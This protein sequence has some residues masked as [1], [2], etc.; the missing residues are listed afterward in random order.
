[1]FPITNYDPPRYTIKGQERNLVGQSVNMLVL[2]KYI[3]H[4][5]ELPTTVLITGETGTGK[6]L[7]AQ[8]IHYNKPNHADNNYPFVAVACSGIPQ[9]L[10]ESLLFGHVR[11]S[12][13]G[14][15]KDQK[16]KFEYAEGGT[17]FLDEIGDMSPYLQA[18]ILRVLQEKEITPVGSNKSKKV[19]AR[20]VSATNT[21]LETKIKNGEFRA[22]L[23]HRIN[24][25]PVHIP[26]LRDRTEDIEPLCYYFIE[27]FN[28]GYNRQIEGIT[29]NAVKKLKGY[30]WP[31]N[32]RE[33]E[34][35]IERVFV[36]KKS[37]K[38]HFSDIFFEGNLEIPTRIFGRELVADYIKSRLQALGKNQSWLAQE[39][40]ISR[41]AV[42][43]YVSAEYFPEG[44]LRKKLIEVLELDSNL[45]NMLLK[46]NEQNNQN[47]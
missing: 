7:V 31:G 18:K 1:M 43:G 12:F 42:S 35:V 45:I 15:Y 4:L 32:V 36:H 34:N 33:L 9:E 37:G 17:I 25:F 40:R 16:G 10:L 8:A 47:L 46:N 13:T 28:K 19:N 11:G 3:N 39:L 24:V 23:F 21:D 6:E 38:I 44:Q 20:V 22:D 27:R 26:S 5:V 2:F 29:D 41:E 14:A 30:E